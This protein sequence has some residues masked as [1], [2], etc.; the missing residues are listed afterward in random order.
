MADRL[1][2]TPTPDGWSQGDQH[3]SWAD[4]DYKVKWDS[5]L[6]LCKGVAA[7]RTDFQGLDS[8]LATQA[9]R[10][11][12]LDEQSQKDNVKMAPNALQ[13]NRMA[14]AAADN[15][16]REHVHLKFFE[17]SDEWK[18]WGIVCQVARNVWL[19]VGPKQRIRPEQWPRVRLPDPEPEP[20][21]VVPVEVTNLL[22]APFVVGPH[23]R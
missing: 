10:Q 22:A 15:V 2:W 9:L 23:Q 17:P 3:F 16:T 5:A 6:H 7:S 11:L 19:L 20:D 14:G 13:G 4:A 18:C 1:N 21:Q 8:C 12:K